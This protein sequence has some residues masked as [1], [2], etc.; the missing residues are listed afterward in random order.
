MYSFALVNLCQVNEFICCFQAETIGYVSRVELIS[1][2]ESMLLGDPFHFLVDWPPF[3]FIRRHCP[4]FSPLSS[5]MR[6]KSLR[7]FIRAESAVLFYRCLPNKTFTVYPRRNNINN[8]I[9]PI[10]NPNEVRSFLNNHID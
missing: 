2:L 6:G 3:A 7:R 5:L 1:Y 8:Q 4:S 9:S 10:N